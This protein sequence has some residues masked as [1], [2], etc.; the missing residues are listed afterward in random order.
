MK[1]FFSFGAKEQIGP[2]PA[3]GKNCVNIEMCHFIITLYS[4]KTI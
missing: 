3:G 2:M 1:S 4:F